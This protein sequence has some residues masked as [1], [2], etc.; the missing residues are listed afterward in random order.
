MIMNDECIRIW[1]V[2]AMAYFTVLSQNFH[3]ETKI[4]HKN[5][6]V[7]VASIPAEILSGYLSNISVYCLCYTN[8]LTRSLW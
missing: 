4:N 1:K 7:R 6:S 2:A 5:T 3:M 8:L